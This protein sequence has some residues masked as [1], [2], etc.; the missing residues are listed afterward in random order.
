MASSGNTWFKKLEAK[1]KRFKQRLNGNTFQ[2][3]LNRSQTPHAEKAVAFK[4][5]Q[6]LI[7]GSAH[8]K[9]VNDGGVIIAAIFE[10]DGVPS[11]EFKAPKTN[12]ERAAEDKR[13]ALPMKAD[14]AP[15]PYGKM[16][17]RRLA[18]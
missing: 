10:G 5:Q 1:Q 3:L 4:H 6:A 17:R 9:Y 15:K 13:S 7:H 8:G 18:A 2:P 12:A 14:W 11:E 16:N